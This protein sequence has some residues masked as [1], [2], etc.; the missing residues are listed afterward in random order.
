M[1]DLPWKVYTLS[2]KIH[3]SLEKMKE[4]FNSRS[5]LLHT[6]GNSKNM[7]D[8][9]NQHMKEDQIKAQ[10]INLSLLPSDFLYHFLFCTD[11][12]ILTSHVHSAH[13]NPPKARY[14]LFSQ[15]AKHICRIVILHGIIHLCDTC[16]SPAT[17]KKCF[18]ECRIM[19]PHSL[20]VHKW[21]TKRITK[22]MHIFDQNVDQWM[23][24]ASYEKHMFCMHL[25]DIKPPRCF[26]KAL[27]Y[28]TLSFIGIA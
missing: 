14:M 19:L 28:F 5:L 4:I 9:E 22:F 8:L 10:S 18:D 20:G 7:T 24:R 16:I 6:I 21:I 2:P 12:P 3:I 1:E 26:L 25:W 27:Q 23:N 11:W 13:I 15:H 17:K